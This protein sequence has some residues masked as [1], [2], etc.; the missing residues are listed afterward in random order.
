MIARR[1]A[2]AALA[3][4]AGLVGACGSSDSVTGATADI[5]GAYTL[6]TVGKDTLPATVFDS[7][8]TE[9]GVR[10]TIAITGGTMTLS[11]AGGYIFAMT[12][13]FVVNATSQPVIPLGDRGTYTRSDSTLAFS[14]IDGQG[15]MS[16]T[17][18]DGKLAMAQDLLDNGV[19]LILVYQK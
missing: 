5:G 3:A 16:G 11:S 2:L 14:S 1:T 17:L 10:V 19:P 15:T 9:A 7:T 4:A 12:Y 6:R 13:T 18:T 8:Y